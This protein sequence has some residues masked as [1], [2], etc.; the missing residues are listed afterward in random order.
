MNPVAKLQEMQKQRLANGPELRSVSSKIEIR[1]AS[2][3]G[4]SP[5]IF[6]Y[7]AKFNERSTGLGY[8][9]EIIMPGAF[10][11]TDFS[12][13]AA[14]FNHD[15]NII[16]GSVRGNS[17][18][19][20]IDDTGLR[21]EVTPPDNQ[22]IKDMVIGPMQRGDLVG[23][24]FH[25]QMDYEDP[26]A[27]EW[28]WDTVNDVAVRKINKISRVLDVCPVLYPA[29]DTSD[30]AL[31]KAGEVAENVKQKADE[32]ELASKAKNIDIFHLL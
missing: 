15:E 11:N 10:D 6:G 13:C 30:S 29:Y 20:T 8:F 3:G 26:T 25:F 18:K 16:L 14:L 17:L 9:V 19:L 12:S 31:R 27:E 24:S 4:S 7:A 21:Y 32:A 28:V 23:S 2:E 22:M 1:A 5:V